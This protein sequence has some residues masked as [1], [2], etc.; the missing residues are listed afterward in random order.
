LQIAPSARVTIG[1]GATV[2]Y[3]VVNQVGVAVPDCALSWGTS[4]SK[5]ATV[6]ATG[7]ATGKLVG[8]PIAVSART[9]TRPTLSVSSTLIVGAAVA[10][11]SISPANADVQIGAS[12]LLTVTVRDA[13]GNALSDR[14]V[15][16]SS[17]NTTTASVSATGTVNGL[18]A[19][20]TTITANVE[21]KVASA[22]IAVI[23]PPFPTSGLLAFYPLDG[24]VD[25]ASGNGRHGTLLAGTPA[26]NRFG[27]SAASLKF[28]GVSGGFASPA[29]MLN[30]GQQGYTVS[31]WV[32]Y[33]QF[34]GWS[35]IGGDFDALVVTTP[36]N[37]FAVGLDY[38][39]QGRMTAAVG[40]GSTW[41]SVYGVGAK[42]GYLLQ[43][44]YH[45]AFR[46]NGSDF[47]VWVDGVVDYQ[48]SHATLTGLN[49][50]VTLNFGG[51]WSFPN[52]P[53]WG[54]MS[55][56]LDDIRVYGRALTEDE[57]RTLSNDRPL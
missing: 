11:V 9:T 39:V 57:I 40:D 29:A 45:V 49:V 8:G 55:G 14:I 36:H 7:L 16:W 6:S 52:E 51:G 4:N 44:W 48:V 35:R 30:V 54:T 34:L 23:P 10:T 2:D 18:N 27:R 53:G 15:R 50:P 1:V 28:D 38:N 56:S 46:K 20:S 47:T 42:T 17:S 12:Q 32:S 19:G 43:R 22:A 26:P 13:N 25:D 21:G 41:Y 31:L 37:G 5:I 3:N 24:N 33:D